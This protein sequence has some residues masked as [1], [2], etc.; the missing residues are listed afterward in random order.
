MTACQ[1]FIHYDD[2]SGAVNKIQEVKPADPCIFDIK[3][4]K[5][6]RFSK[7]LN[8]FQANTV[9]LHARA[10]LFEETDWSI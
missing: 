9:I 4:F 8:N 3:P 7:S 1:N 2:L 6:F 5:S 10:S